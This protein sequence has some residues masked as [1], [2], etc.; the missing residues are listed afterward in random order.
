[1]EEADKAGSTRAA[2]GSWIAAVAA[3]LAAL[4]AGGSWISTYRLGSTELKLTVAERNNER[5]SQ[6]IDQLGREGGKELTLRL[7]G[8]YALEQVMHDADSH[9][10]AIVDVLCAFVRE[11]TRAKVDPPRNPTPDVQAALTALV[12]RPNI[13]KPRFGRDAKFGVI[14]LRRLSGQ[15]VHIEITYWRDAHLEGALLTGTSLDET[16]FQLAHLEGA[17]LKEAVLLGAN[18]NGANLTGAALANAYVDGADF[19]TAV[20]LTTEGVRRVCLGKH[21]TKFPPGV[22]GPTGKVDGC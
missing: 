11:H 6:A 19:S 1:M 4:A 12:H 13:G 9:E 15:E 10:A 22:T 14:D 3:L 17:D 20:G 8:I 7:G 21:R 2:W 18:F 16:D 5:F